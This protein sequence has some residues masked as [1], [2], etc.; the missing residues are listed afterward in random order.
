MVKPKI[1]SSTSLGKNDDLHERSRQRFLYGALYQ[2]ARAELL[3]GIGAS[4]D[5]VKDP[6][7]YYALNAQAGLY[8]NTFGLWILE[9]TAGEALD[10]LAKKFSSVVDEFVRWNAL[11]VPFRL[12]LKA[13]YAR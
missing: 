1:L 5:E 6:D 4:A 8:L 2:N 12:A 13:E 3:K 9:Y 10:T 7:P 11:N